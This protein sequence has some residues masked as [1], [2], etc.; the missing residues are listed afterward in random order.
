MGNLHYCSEQAAASAAW[1]AVSAGCYQQ[2]QQERGTIHL[3]FSASCQL[4]YL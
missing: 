4:L 1:P 3:T 2:L